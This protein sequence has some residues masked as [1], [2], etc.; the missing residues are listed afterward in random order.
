MSENK[1]L[2][3]LTQTGKEIKINGETL[4]IK[5]FKL[6]ALPKITTALK[7]IMSD[8]LALLAPNN[9]IIFEKGKEI[10]IDEKGWA[11][12][13]DAIIR[14]IDAIVTI[15]SAYTRKPREWFLDEETGID[16]EETVLLAFA[17]LEKHFDFFTQRLAPLV[18]QIKI[19]KI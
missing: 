12:I 7:S 15:L 14:N 18:E 16:I 1:G 9:G 13:N 5:A 17:I 4:E 11:L 10:S 3:I 2:E 8:V 6:A 19:K